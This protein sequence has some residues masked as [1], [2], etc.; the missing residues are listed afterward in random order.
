MVHIGN[1][2]DKILEN[3]FAGV[4]YASLRT[5]LV[6]EYRTQIIHPDAGDIFNALK[7]TSFKDT[8]AVILGQDPYHGPGEAHGLSFSVRPGIKIPPSLINIFT[9]QQSDL[10][11]F[12]PDNGYLKSWAD[13]GV[14]LLN[15]V[16][17]VRENQPLSHRGK[18]WEQVTDSIISALNS[19]E[20]SVV[21]L[22]WGAQAKAKKALIT[23]TRHFILETT[24]PSPL[25]AHY[26]FFGC[27]HFSMCNKILKSLG[28]KEIKW[29]IENI[30]DKRV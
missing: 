19:R 25:S 29:Q 4:G 5:F 9:E 16:L 6:E 23:N 1:D 18:G 27:R 8:K 22:L 28:K 10:G 15:A 26:G 17:T 13:D 20:D 3:V 11:N 21:F 24:H 12:I 30:G 2:W 7:Y 14:L